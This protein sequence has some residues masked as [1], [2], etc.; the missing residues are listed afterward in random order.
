MLHSACRAAW[1][2]REI[3]ARGTCREDCFGEGFRRSDFESPRKTLF[4]VAYR[5]AWYDLGSVFIGGSR[6]GSKVPGRP[7]GKLSSSLGTLRGTKKC[8]E[9]SAEP[10]QPRR[11]SYPARL[12]QAE[13]AWL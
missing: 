4:G 5:H 8:P 2:Y 1:P 6:N 3:P 10:A 7:C 9:G 12:G 13:R 11:S